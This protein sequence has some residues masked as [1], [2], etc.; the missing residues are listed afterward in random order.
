M[1]ANLPWD[2]FL[3]LTSPCRHG[4]TNIF[5]LDTCLCQGSLGHWEYIPYKCLRHLHNP[6]PDGASGRQ[7]QAKRRQ[8]QKEFDELGETVGLLLCLTQ[9]LFGTLQR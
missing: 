1:A 2:G 9:D 7:G 3:V 6:L 4:Q 8:G 5:V